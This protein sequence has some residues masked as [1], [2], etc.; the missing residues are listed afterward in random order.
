MGTEIN[1]PHSRFSISISE[2]LLGRTLTCPVCKKNYEVKF[3]T[4]PVS[5]QPDSSTQTLLPAQQSEQRFQSPNR[6]FDINN[7]RSKFIRFEI[8]A[9]GFDNTQLQWRVY[10][11]N[12]PSNEIETFYMKDIEKIEFSLKEES[13]SVF[14]RYLLAAVLFILTGG[15]ITIVIVYFLGLNWFHPR[16]GPTIAIRFMRKQKRSNAQHT[17]HF[18]SEKEILNLRLF[19]QTWLPSC[20]HNRI[21]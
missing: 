10:K 12:K 16:K 2:S 3:D 14:L 1:C 9:A 15:L 6:H 13:G 21:C 8:I 4:E 17:L 5:D 19:L 18:E 20:F 11:N 7:G